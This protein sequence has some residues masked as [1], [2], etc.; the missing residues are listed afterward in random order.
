MYLYTRILVLFSAVP[1]VEP[2]FDSTRHEKPMDLAPHL[3]NTSLRGHHCDDGVRLLEELIDCRTLSKGLEDNA[4]LAK[5]D[6]DDIVS[7]IVDILAETFKAGLETPIHFQVRRLSV[8]LSYIFLL[9]T[10]D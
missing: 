8:S 7:Q 4:K 5:T 10:G 2:G 6:V 1:Y 9:L 3:T